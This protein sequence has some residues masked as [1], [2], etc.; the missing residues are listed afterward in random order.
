MDYI[1]YLE[2]VSFFGNTLWA[3]ATGLVA[4]FVALIALKLFQLIVIARLKRLAEKTKND[5]DDALISAISQIKPIFYIVVSLYIGLRFTAMPDWL[6]RGADIVLLLVVAQQVIRAIAKLMDYGIRK[7]SRGGA[8]DGD[9]QERKHT[10]AMARIMESFVVITLWVIVLLF[11]LSNFGIDVTSMVAGLGIGGIAI[12]LA[13]QN[14]LGDIFSSFSIF[15]DKPFEVGHFIQVGQDSGTVE[16]IGL[17]TT[18]LRTLRGE[19]LVI[20]NKE[21]TSARLQNF[22]TLERR[23]DSFQ[24][25]IVYGLTQTTLKKVP[26]IVKKVVTKAGAQFDRCHLVEFGDSSL[27]YEL[28]YFVDSNDFKMYLNTKQSILLGIYTQFAKEGI[29]FAYPT[30]VIHIEQD[31]A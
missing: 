17:K 20:S 13:I 1:E 22:K 15:I 9:A 19:E 21:L 28:V 4:F 5:I 24:F 23:R 10:A 25:G 18:R 11:L 7:Y 6:D 16:K 14:I 29:E 27:N 3:Y 8:E 31:E 30:Q 12:A 26:T 2:S